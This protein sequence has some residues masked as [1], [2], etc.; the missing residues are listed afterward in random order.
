MAKHIARYCVTSGLRG[1]YMP[2]STS[3]PLVC[4]TRRDLANAIREEIEA[5]GFPLATFGQ[6]D[7]RRRWAFIKR[8]GSSVAH[9]AIYHGAYEIAFHGLTEAEADAMEAEDN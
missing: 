7:L 8:N 2:N 4:E 6:A 5:Q 1:C 3:G 9:F